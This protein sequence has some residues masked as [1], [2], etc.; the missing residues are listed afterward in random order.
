MPLP[1]RVRRYL[2]RLLERDA[3]ERAQT[4]AE[5]DALAQAAEE[6]GA[7]PLPDVL[8]GWLNNA[9]GQ[10]RW[11]RARPVAAKELADHLSDQYE[12]FVDEGMDEDAAAEATMREMGDAVETG[13][14][15]DRAW[16]PQP[17]WV[18]LGI[19]LA[20]AA[21]GLVVQYGLRPHNDLEW[22]MLLGHYV[23]GTICLFFGYFLDYTI[24]GRH[25]K[26][27][28]ALWCAIGL[29]MAFG[30]LQRI[31]SG[32]N[33]YLRRWVW[34]FPVLFA[35]ILYS[36]RG[37][38]TS[39]IR[40]CLLYML[41]MWFF[42][43]FA[44]STP[45]LCVLTT[46]CCGMLFAAVWHGVFGKRT[47]CKMVLSVL[48]LLVILEFGIWLIF[49]I[50]HLWDRVAILFYPQMDAIGNGYQ[51]SVIQNIMFGIPAPGIEP[52]DT[53]WLFSW[54]DGI[55][56][57]ILATVKLKFGWAG[58]L[59]LLGLEVL[60]L[61]WGFRVA[62]RQTG[63]LARSVCMGVMLTFTLQTAL[64]VLQNF[65]FILLAAYGLPLLSYG[66]NYLLQTMFLLGVLLSA[67][68]TGR[69][70]SGL[71]PRVS[72]VSEVGK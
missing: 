63:L 48:P 64:Y 38:G 2:I 68:R 16:R 39:G 29:L 43:M 23:V 10:M 57:W 62:R 25:C 6:H 26:L 56:D 13:T 71:A 34:F 35:G 46:V 40:N 4:T 67:Q 17:D 52:I 55:A 5:L 47:K 58:F 1:E 72:R 45:A 42:A 21:V 28:Y 70:E 7:R 49:N 69:L 11:K 59:I 22:Y 14:R 27:L 30:P 24:F 37:K 9:T 20:V 51:G 53:N 19:V 61:L 3:A 32:A 54:N 12:A 66:A 8:R 33:I 41:G 18:M 65:G 44:P 60:F 50:P 15:L 36:Q 31:Q